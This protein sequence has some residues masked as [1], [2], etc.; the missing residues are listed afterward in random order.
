MGRIAG[1]VHRLAL[2]AAVVLAVTVAACSGDDGDD[3]GGPGLDRAASSS[4]ASTAT[5]STT[6]PSTTTTADPDLVAVVDLAV[7]DCFDEGA[8]REDEPSRLQEVELVECAREHRNEVYAAVDYEAG[9]S[10]AYPGNG[11]LAQFA[12]RQC[13]SRFE[14]YVG[15][16]VERTGYGIGT[17]YPDEPSWAEGDRAVLCVLYDADDRPLTGSQKDAEA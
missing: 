2:V 13:V 9:A 14:A 6:A 15:A 16:P 7:G 5:T 11:E 10:A 1:A 8:V 3:G 4:S 12:Q 17:I